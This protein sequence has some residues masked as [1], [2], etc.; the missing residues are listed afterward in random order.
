MQRLNAWP[1]STARDRQTSLP[2]F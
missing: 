2:V 1:S